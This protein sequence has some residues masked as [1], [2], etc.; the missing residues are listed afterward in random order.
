MTMSMADGTWALRCYAAAA[1]VMMAGVGAAV[2]Q[3]P[4]EFDWVYTVISKLGSRTHNP[5]GGLWLSG[6]LLV[7]VLLLWPVTRALAAAGPQGSA[8]P[9]VPIA[10]LRAGLAGGALL[11]L[12][13][14]FGLQLSWLGRKGHELVALVT[15]LGLYAAVLGLYLH[16]IRQSISFLWPALLVLLPLGAVAVSQVAVY[17]DQRELGWVNTAWREM[18]I[19]FWLSFAFWQWLAVA[20]LGIGLGALLTIREAAPARAAD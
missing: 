13:G 2:A 8:H 9:R 6:A 5:V 11:A 3:F 17:F 19:P 7:A 12:E 16:R 14:L 15:F 18:G 4:G 10:A 20:F 1:L